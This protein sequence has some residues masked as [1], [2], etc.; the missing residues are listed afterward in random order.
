MSQSKEAK[1]MELLKQI[2]DKNRELVDSE[3]LKNIKS[4]LWTHIALIENMEDEVT[5]DE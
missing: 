3:D 2:K 1:M 5:V 4:W